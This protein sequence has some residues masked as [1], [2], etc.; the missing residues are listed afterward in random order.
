MW[1]VTP[2]TVILKGMSVSSLIEMQQSCGSYGSWLFARG[3]VFAPETPVAPDDWADAEFAGMQVRYDRRLTANS[4]CAGAASVFC[5][6]VIFDT[7][8]PEK[9]GAS[10]VGDLAAALAFSEAEFLETL[11]N[12]CGRFVIAY[13]KSSGESFLL[14]DAAG[15]RSAL[16]ATGAEKVVASHMM[17]AVLNSDS[18]PLREDIRFK[19]GYPGVRTPRKNIRVL[20]PNTKIDLGS[21][22]IERYWPLSPLSP[23][24]IDEAVFQFRRRLS[25]ASRWIRSNYR[26]LAS[27]TAGLDSRAT[28]SILKGEGEYFTYCLNRPDQPGT[29]ELDRDFA[30]AI[31]DRFKINHQLLTADDIEEVEPDFLAMQKLNTFYRH[32]PK[33]V[34]AYMKRLSRSEEDIHIRSNL[35]EIGRRFYQHRSVYPRSATSLTQ[36]YS[37]RKRLHSKAH[38]E[39]FDEFSEVTS[40]FDAPVERTSLFYW[41]HRM[42]AWHSQVALE[43]DPAFESVSLYNCRKTLE[44]MLAVPFAAQERSILMKATV[45]DEWP[46]LAEYD[47]NGEPFN[48]Y[49]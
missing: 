33:M 42:G 29:D 7:R 46:E 26:P 2:S 40:F 15:M 39:A 25:N 12:A 20:T 17:L 8:Y 19:F 3:Y 37:G 1:G 13:R 43:S 34:R 45:Q 4:A 31:R 36:L 14:T 32:L 11:A 49:R 27:L 23:L 18:A 30:L 9:D 5:L 47:L 10:F 38:I 21:F 35:S 6:G 28:L 24:G 41:E 22:T 16:Y 44:L 48:Q